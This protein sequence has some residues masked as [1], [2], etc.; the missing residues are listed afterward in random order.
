MPL[1][2]GVGG[3]HA[4]LVCHALA[5]AKECVVIFAAALAK[6]GAS[7]EGAGAGNVAPLATSFAGILL[8]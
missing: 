1:R 7:V 5:A 3:L 2:A 6:D 8:K 4:R